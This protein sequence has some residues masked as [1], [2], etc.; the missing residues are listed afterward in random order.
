MFDISFVISLNN[1]LKEALKKL[2]RVNRQLDRRNSY[3]QELEEE[4][5]L[6]EAELRMT[7][8]LVAAQPFPMEVSSEEVLPTAIVQ[9]LLPRQPNSFGR[10]RHCE[11]VNC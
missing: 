11:D 6:K 3:C 5:R 7:R 4:L 2:D 10:G 9:P 1:A 8:G